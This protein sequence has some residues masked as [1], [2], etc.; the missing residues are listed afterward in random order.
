MIDP[1]MMLSNEMTHE[2]IDILDSRDWDLLE[3][4]IVVYGH[5]ENTED[6]VTR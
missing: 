4:F 3:H 2:L 5:D 1:G 6:G